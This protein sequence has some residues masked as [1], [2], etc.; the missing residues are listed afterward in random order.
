[1][2]SDTH[3]SVAGVAP[4]RRRGQKSNWSGEAKKR[5]Y[6]IA[7]SCRKQ[8]VKPCDADGHVDG[9]TCSPYRVIYDQRRAHT[10]HTHPDW[11]DGHSDNDGLRIA[12]KAFMKDLWREAKR[13]HEA[14]A[15]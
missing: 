2:R 11:T 14:G 10:S 12:A 5:A 6:R 13:L 8:L 9:C 4:K 7:E 15:A 1:L 3:A